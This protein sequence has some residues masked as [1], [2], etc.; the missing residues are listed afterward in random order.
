[1]K[2]QLLTIALL[3]IT[4]LAGGTAWAWDEPTLVDGV[5]Q[6]GTASEL[7][8]FSEFVAG[9][10]NGETAAVLTADLDFDGVTHTPI[11]PNKDAKF[12]GTFDGQN[13]HIKNLVINTT[14]NYQ[15]IFG[16]VRG[17]STIKN[18]TIDA[19][20]SFTGGDRTAAV[21]ATLNTNEGTSKPMQILNVVNHA[22]VNSASGAV[23]AFI[24]ASDN[25]VFFKIHNCVNTG[26]IKTTGPEKYAVVANGW[27]NGNPGG[28]SQVW[29]VVNTGTISPID[30]TNTFFRGN[31]RSVKDSYDMMNYGKQGTYISP[32]A[33]H[34]GELCYKLNQH[35]TEGQ[36][37]TQDLS[38]PNSI[39]MPIPGPTVY[40]NTDYYCGGTVKGSYTYSN[41]ELTEDDVP[42]DHSFSN[43][44][45]LC[46]FCSYPKED[47]KSVSGDGYYHLSNATDVE[48]FSHMVRDAGHGAM[49]AKLD[50]DIDF[51][52]V[53]NAHLPIGSSGKKYFGHFDGQN[54]RIIGMVLNT[55]SKLNNRGYDGNGFFGSVR[56]GGTDA[57]WE[58]TNNTP[59]IEN[60]IIDASCSI[61]HDN[62]FAAGV[63]AHI[64]SRIDESS[65]IIIRNCGNEANVTTTGKNAAGILGCV[66]GTNVGLKLYNLWN[67]GNIVGYSGESA[68]ICAWT[69]QRNSDGEVD[70]EGCWNIGEVTGIDGNH[71]NMIR[72]NTNIVPRRIFDLCTANGTNGGNQG[73]DTV[74]GTDDPISSGEL[75]YQLNGDQSSISWYQLIGTD[76][77]PM[78]IEKSG[79][80]VYNVDLI[81]CNGDPTETNGTYSNTN[82]AF[83]DHA[84]SNTTGLCTGCSYPDE[85]WKSASGDGYY[86]FS[87]PAEVEWFSRM[88]RIAKH[89]AMNVKLDADIDYDNVTNAHLPIGIYTQKYWGKFDGQGHTIK[90][91]VLVNCENNDNGLG[92]FGCIRVGGAG[93]TSTEIKNLTVEG[94]IT[95]D[96]RNTAG[97][98]GR[99]SEFESGGTVL[100]EN[101]VN[102]AT[103]NTTADYAAGIVGQI[104]NA[105]G[106][107]VTVEKC[108]NEGTVTTTGLCAAGIVSQVND[109]SA[110]LNI[111][112]C[113]NLANVKST[114][115]KNCGGIFG[116]NTKS[117]GV[118]HIINCGNTGDVEGTDE[119][120]SITGWIGSNSGQIISNCW[121]S[122]DLAGLK[123]IQN[124]YRDQGSS[125]TSSNLYTTEIEEGEQGTTITNEQI[126]SGELCYLLN[127]NSCYDVNWTQTIGTDDYPVP[128]NTSGIVNYISSVGYTTQYIPSTDVTIPTGVEAYAGE[129]ADNYLRLLEIEDAI[130]KDDAVILKGS[131][132]YYSFVPTTGVIAATTNNLLGSTGV[133]VGAGDHFY[134]LANKGG[135]GFYPVDEGVKIPAGKAYISLG[136]GSVKGFTFVFDDDDATGIES[137]QNSKFKIQN[138]GSIYNLAGQKLSKMQKG[139]NIVNGK[140]I[141]K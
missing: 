110:N 41:T 19:T 56:G 86:H 50:A 27:S 88:V 136:G 113:L 31:Y 118:I 90:K 130:S 11:G 60:L 84:Y 82:S 74:W 21:V 102:K 125:A 29:N 133:T 32:S 53:P 114:G 126:A 45:G 128:F 38:D 92:F 2:K 121:N 28:N 83:R 79:A 137:I 65:N 116:A 101:C 120:A 43:E 64:N 23:S 33:I 96:K 112:S 5:Y 14:N 3:A 49:N 117:K 37:F 46:T 109:C 106:V 22:N 4:W 103:I 59:I 72:R 141:M 111:E 52:G 57:V 58:V 54:H 91:M 10:S 9:N 48:W 26:N 129:K 1:M 98:V 140:K 105:N 61:E 17:G 25:A 107:T 85:E 18:F 67:K 42:A 123:G 39:P 13:H 89:S 12:N 119:S 78:P 93:N 100:I 36:A 134:A 122:G 87:T 55:A 69:G 99:I 68:A 51:D 94:S 35:E 80:Q 47:W 70:V 8:W 108:I 20:C 115:N 81:H 7:E 76:T 104:F 71:Y 97:I 124:M 132:G 127:G 24:G 139:I 30:G 16:W 15:G 138:E 75:C 34:S 62:N 40:Q 66:E 63:V 77:Y 135:V 6:I 95:N 73:L 131:E 44:T